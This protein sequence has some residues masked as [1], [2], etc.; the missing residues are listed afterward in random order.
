M[1]IYS[2]LVDESIMHTRFSLVVEGEVRWTFTCRMGPSLS[3]G[4]VSI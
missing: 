4:Q 3:K 1:N 2:R